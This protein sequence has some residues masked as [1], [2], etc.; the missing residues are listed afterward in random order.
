MKDYEGFVD[1]CFKNNSDKPFDNSSAEHATVLIKKM[2]EY[3]KKEINIY[4]GCL[5]DGIYG[6]DELVETAKKY[7]SAGG[8]LQ[9]IFQDQLSKS[10]IED[11]KFVQ[12]C[13][14]SNVVFYQL[15]QQYHNTVGNHFSTMDGK[16][17]RL[18]T[19]KDKKLAI[20]SANNEEQCKIFNEIYSNLLNGADKIELSASPQ[21]SN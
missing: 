21:P 5:A 9:I 11:K 13:R 10:S 8:K 19:D 7:L 14:G 15:Q 20:A 17:F 1:E 12:A 2:F 3:G 16:A 4:T 6:N 18:E